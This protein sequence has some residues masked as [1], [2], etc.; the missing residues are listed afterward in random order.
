[1]KKEK[2]TEQLIIAAINGLC[3]KYGIVGDDASD[4]YSPEE[5]AEYAIK[6]SE[7]VKDKLLNN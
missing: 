2:F 1:M 5:I 7:I 3:A 4:F 6:L